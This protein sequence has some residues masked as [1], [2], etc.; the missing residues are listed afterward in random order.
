[1]IGSLLVQI[2]WIVV[3]VRCLYLLFTYFQKHRKPWFDILFYA[4]V[5]I[6]SLSFLL[7]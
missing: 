5:A 7:R 1:M 2:A 4:S 6:I 3:L